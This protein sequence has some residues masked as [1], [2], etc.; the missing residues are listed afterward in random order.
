[1][2]TETLIKAYEVLEMKSDFLLQQIRHNETDTEEEMKKMQMLCDLHMDVRRKMMELA[3]E[4]YNR[5][6]IELIDK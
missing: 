1:M 5:I 6:K 2:K 4:I 3:D